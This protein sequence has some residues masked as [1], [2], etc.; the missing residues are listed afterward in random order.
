MKIAGTPSFDIGRVAGFLT[1]N[2]KNGDLATIRSPA[3]EIGPSDP[4]LTYP[5]R[6]PTEDFRPGPL[7]VKGRFIDLYV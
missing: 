5:A 7:P 2:S 3:P 6:R 1:P 4:V